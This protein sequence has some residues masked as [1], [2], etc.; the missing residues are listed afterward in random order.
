MTNCS[1]KNLNSYHILGD[2]MRKEIYNRAKAK[3]YAKK[4]AYTRNP[5]YYNF[6][7]IGGDC[8]SFISQCIYAGSG[9]MN[10]T[11]NT[12]WYYNSINDRS[13]SWSGVEFLYNFLIKNKSVGPR[14][15][16]VELDKIEIGDIIQLSFDGIKFSH[17]LMVVNIGDK[18][19][20]DNI[21]TA[22]H[23]YDSYNR[24]VS[25]YRFEDIRYVHINSV[26]KW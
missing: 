10:Y 24:R 11:K 2:M 1:A 7:S 18:L 4:W 19:D 17:T 12:G 26:Y 6:D 3:E 23:T 20:L 13:P 9:I 25:S 15:N 14:G 22:S 5:K 16:K 8:T 21:Y